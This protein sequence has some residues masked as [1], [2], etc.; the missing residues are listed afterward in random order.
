MFVSS[1]LHKNGMRLLIGTLKF[2]SFSKFDAAMLAC[3]EWC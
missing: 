2:G 3:K 1:V